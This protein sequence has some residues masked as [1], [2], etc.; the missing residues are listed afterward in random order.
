MALRPYESFRIGPSATRPKKL[1]KSIAAFEDDDE[2]AT[3]AGKSPTHIAQATGRVG[4]SI[5]EENKAAAAKWVDQGST[6]AEQGDTAA[7]LRCWDQALLIHPGDGRTHEMR[8]QVLNAE[9][10]SFEAVQAAQQAV[11]LCPDWPE[12]HITLARVQLNLG[13]PLLALHSYQAAAK[14][15]PTHPDLVEEL[16]TAQMYAKLHARQQQQ[17]PGSRAHVVKHLP[18]HPGQTEQQSGIGTQADPNP[19]IGPG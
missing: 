13:E 16:P 6:F 8:A 11:S 14:L 10:R 15:S 2:D 9:G 4:S 19:H 3:A 1:L 12:A 5:T 17:Q 18:S 7:A